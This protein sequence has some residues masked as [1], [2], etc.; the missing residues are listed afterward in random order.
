MTQQLLLPIL[1]LPPISYFHAIAKGG[2]EIV[3]DQHEHFPKQTYRT[4]TSIATANGILDLTVP[5]IHRRK[6][7]VPMQ[8]IRIN[9]DHQW[10]RLHWLSLQAAYRRSA[11][12]EY[13]EDDF[14]HFYEQKYERLIDFNVELLQVLL[15]C[16]KLQKNISLSTSFEDYRNDGTDLRQIIHPK[17]ESII[18]IQKEYFQVFGEKNGFLKDMSI[19]D[20]LFNQG[21][22]SKNF[23]I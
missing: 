20:L 13:Y 16:L 1:Y 12:F 3:L 7:H 19:V 10:Q 6:D 5:I 17:R 23:L 9:Y 15:K 11:Y 21:P 14:A 22:Q 4:R 8:N 2:N 18:P